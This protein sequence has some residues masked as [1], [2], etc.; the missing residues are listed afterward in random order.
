[1]PNYTPVVCYPDDVYPDFMVSLSK[2]LKIDFLTWAEPNN[3]RML[4]QVDILINV[5][6]QNEKVFQEGWNYINF[7]ISKLMLEDEEGTYFYI[8]N[9]KKAVLIRVA[10]MYVHELQQSISIPSCFVGNS[11][12]YGNLLEV[13]SDGLILTSL[14]SFKSIVYKRD[15]KGA[16]LDAEIKA[17]NEIEIKYSDVIKKQRIEHSKMILVEEEFIF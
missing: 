11:F 16:I 7:E 10:D 3:G 12:G 4:W 17:V 15:F 6:N 5:R 13:F 14:Q 8:P 1:M 2:K 9:E